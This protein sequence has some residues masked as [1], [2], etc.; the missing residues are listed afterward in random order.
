MW[1][2]NHD[3]RVLGLHVYDTVHA[4]EMTTTSIGS[5]YNS[6]QLGEVICAV[7]YRRIQMKNSC[8]FTSHTLGTYVKFVSVFE[9][10]LHRNEVCSFG[11]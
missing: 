7:S 4:W 9:V 5:H 1:L 8:R 2:H 6:T 10:A 3:H 11:Q